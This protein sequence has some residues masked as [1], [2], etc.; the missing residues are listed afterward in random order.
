MPIHYKTIAPFLNTGS[1]R[2]AMLVSYTGLA[3]GILL[4]F[5]SVQMYFNTNQLLK[6]KNPRK[7]GFDFVSVTKTITNEN[8]GAANYFT[9]ADIQ[10]IKAQPFI[11][12]AAPLVSNQFR[13][14][15]SAGSIIP[16]STDLF[17]EAIQNDF[18]DTIQENFTWQPGQS[19]LPIIF[20][21]DFLEMYNVFAPA[22]GLPQLSAGSVGAVNIMIECSGP[23]GTKTTFTGQIVGLS[24]RVNSILVPQP[25]LVWANANF[26]DGP[27]QAPSRIFVKTTDANQV[28]FLNFLDLKNYSIN[29]DKTKFGR[30]KQIL[31]TVVAALG[32]FAVLVIMLALILF[33][34][35]LQLM[36]AKSKDNLA[37]LLTL[38]YAPAWLTGTVTK[39][40]IPTYAAIIVIAI[41]C[42]Q[43]LQYLFWQTFAGSKEA[44][45]PLL[46]PLLLVLAVVL[47]AL[48]I[49]VNYRILKKT[50]YSL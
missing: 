28:S 34:F 27:P 9:D 10:E 45:S 38:G 17:L 37:L 4:L 14:K 12:D 50:L 43:L 44:L 7:D 30:V 5:C 19:L 23:L 20:S 47:M 29:K 35:Y 39:R 21:S 36:I 46:H 31:Q 8:M 49:I 33:S 41:L 40:W 15:A 42:T 1:S 32:G 11:A 24:D 48:C 22:Q 13:A 18:L 3:V 25:F 2:T 6:S 26:G 16:F